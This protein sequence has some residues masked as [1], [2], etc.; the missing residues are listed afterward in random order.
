LKP[1][2]QRQRLSPKAFDGFAYKLRR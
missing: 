2:V 1:V